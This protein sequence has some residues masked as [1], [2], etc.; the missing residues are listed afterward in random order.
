MIFHRHHSMTSPNKHTVVIIAK[1]YPY[2]HFMITFH[3][4]FSVF[5]CNVYSFH[6]S[7]MNNLTKCLMRRKKQIGSTVG[8]AN[9]RTDGLTDGQRLL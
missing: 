6:C 3:N 7:M 1:I 4:L 8:R 2:I 5:K 9:G